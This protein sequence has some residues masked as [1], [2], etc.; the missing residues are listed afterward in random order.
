MQYIANHRTEAI[1]SKKPT[2]QTPVLIAWLIMTFTLSWRVAAITNEDATNTG[3]S[4]RR[5]SIEIP[6]KESLASI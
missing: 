6:M 2:V 4:Q 5:Y 3:K 1:A